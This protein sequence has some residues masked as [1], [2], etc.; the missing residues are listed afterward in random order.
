[1]KGEVCIDLVKNKRKRVAFENKNIY[2]K[3]F[4]PW[5]ESKK[6]LRRFRTERPK[7]T[8]KQCLDLQ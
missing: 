7:F 2:Y 1:M 4:L 8:E 5:H 3:M 6:K